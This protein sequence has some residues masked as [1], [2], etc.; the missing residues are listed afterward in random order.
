MLPPPLR[1]STTKPTFISLASPAQSI[2][3][4]RSNPPLA[5]PVPSN[6]RIKSSDEQ[7]LYISPVLSNDHPTSKNFA[8][9]KNNSQFASLAPR[10]HSP[11]PNQSGF[12]PGSYISGRSS[13]HIESAFDGRKSPFALN[14]ME[15]KVIEKENEEKKANFEKV[16]LWVKPNRDAHKELVKC[17]SKCSISV[18]CISFLC[19]PLILGCL[20]NRA[21]ECALCRRNSFSRR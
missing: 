12:I 7:S 20:S 13:P 14:D 1:A 16:A 10:N 5:R 3:N 17:L 8:F 9:G 11:E 4:N 19:Q 18:V 21:S 15:A 6:G 2:P